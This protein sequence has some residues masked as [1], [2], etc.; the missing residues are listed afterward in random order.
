MARICIVI[1]IAVLIS[2]CAQKIVQKGKATFYANKFDGRRT[3]SGVVFRNSKNIA[4]HRTLP[5]GTK[6]KVTNLRTGKSTK[7]II[8]DRGPFVASRIIDLSKSSAKNIGFYDG[9]TDVKI[10]YKKK[11]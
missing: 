1:L 8:Q 11:R 5:F 7:V 10:S 3:A 2:S 4:A 6:V 9:I